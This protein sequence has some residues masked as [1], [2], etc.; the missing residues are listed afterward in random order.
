M[1][2]KWLQDNKEE[3]QFNLN[4]N[5]P[6]VINI[7]EQYE[8]IYPHLLVQYN[9][10]NLI[11]GFGKFNYMK[12]IVIGS[13]TKSSCIF[14]YDFLIN[15]L[16]GIIDYMNNFDIQ[17]D[18]FWTDK[19]ENEYQMYCWNYKTNEFELICIEDDANYFIRR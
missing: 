16:N 6:N 17:C 5:I 2:I 18:L 12:N 1:D 14:R 13:Y 7:I 10:W 15:N 3:L 8:L 11:D 4:L 19:K 9:D